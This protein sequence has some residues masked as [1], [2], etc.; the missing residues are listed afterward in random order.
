MPASTTQCWRWRT[1]KQ[2][3]PWKPCAPSRRCGAMTRCSMRKPSATSSAIRATWPTCARGWTRQAL[4]AGL[5]VLEQLA[6]VPRALDVLPEFLAEQVRPVGL[7]E[8]IQLAVTDQPV[9]GIGLAH[10][11]AG[12][13]HGA[14]VGELWRVTHRV[15][16][17]QR[18]VLRAREA[19]DVLIPGVF[20]LRL[21]RSGTL[22]REIRHGIVALD[23][24]P[25]A[26]GGCGGRRQERQGGESRQQGGE[27]EQATHGG[28]KHSAISVKFRKFFG[29]GRRA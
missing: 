12:Q 28:R 19:P 26:G 6:V 29:T 3:M 2:G 21:A 14:E 25:H 16:L 13:C 20:E 8:E 24:E 9:L 18:A 27:Q 22:Q 11:A 15:G 7:A 17:E 10:L 5:L 4:P 1:P 23:P